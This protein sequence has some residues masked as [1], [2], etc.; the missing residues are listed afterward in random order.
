MDILRTPDKRFSSLPNFS[1]DMSWIDIPS[2]VADGPD[3][4]RMGFVDAGPTAAEPVLL[5]HGEPSWSFLYRKMIPVL[6]DA[7][8][9]V[10][11]PDLIGFGRSDKPTEVADHTY[12]R[13]VAWMKAFI[14]ELDL[15]RITLFCQD[16]GG[17][18]GLRVLAEQPDRFART[19][20]ANTGLP[21]GN[22][23]MPDV[24]QQF[25]DMVVNS[26]TLEIGRVVESGCARSVTSD[27]KAA[28]N[29]PFPDES[30]KAG[31]EQCRT[32]Y[33]KLPTTLQATPTARLGRSSP[34]WRN[35]SWLRSATQIR[36]PPAVAVC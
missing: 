29:A 1:F 25:R 2:A 35:P 11:A 22:F 34:S 21:V 7:G 4:L 33:H 17:L 26:E 24:W 3:T 13:H 9:R 10:V 5:L 30:Y 12:A 6:V 19:V 36:S 28:Y 16:W 31:P 18:I 32:S 20:A 27:A 15:R 14:D 8:H 23:R